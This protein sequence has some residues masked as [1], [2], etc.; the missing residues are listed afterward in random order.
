MAE[1]FAPTN[2]AS[3]SVHIDSKVIRPLRQRRNGPGLVFLLQWGIGLTLTGMLVWLALG[4]GWIW[5]AMAIHG[6]LLT[7]PTYALSHE[8]AHGTA[9]RTRW[10]NEAILW[11]SS[12][13]YMEE[14]LH[15]RY[16]HT[17]H[18]TYTWHQHLDSQMPFDLPM[19]FRIWVFEIAGLSLLRYH[20]VRLVQM[21]CAQYSPMIRKVVPQDEL[22]R[23][24]R[25]A[26]IFILLYTIIAISIFLGHNWLLWFLVL[27]RLLGVPIMQSFT[28]LQHAE[29]AVNSPSILETTR[30]FRTNWLGRSLYMNMN[31]HVEHHLYPN[32]PFFA[33]PALGQALASQIPEPDPGFWRTSL[34]LVS[35]VLR[36]SLGKSTRARSIRQAPQMITEGAIASTSKATM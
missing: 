10:L 6:G 3:S 7:L 26:W 32:T 19:T 24:T 33:L 2:A 35:V 13:L 4:S 34:E 17:N 1:R 18:H 23:L 16:T 27:P 14:P 36:R 5:P 30:S 28:I 29:T 31:F 20:I 25:N 21:A 22:P 11:F 8:T 15:R 12:I 9:Y